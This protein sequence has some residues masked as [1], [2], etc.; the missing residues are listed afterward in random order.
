[1]S[2][3]VPMYGFGGGGGAALNFKVVG[4]TSTPASPKENMIW[5]KTEK[6][7]AWHFSATQ[8]EGMQ[9]LDVWFPTGTSSPVE[10]NALKRNA[11]QV[12]PKSCMQYNNGVLEAKEAY[13]YQNAERVQFSWTKLYLYR[14]GDQCTE[15]TGGWEKKSYGGNA[16][17]PTAT[18]ESDSIKLVSGDS[19]TSVIIGC[20]NFNPSILKNFKTMCVIGTLSRG[21]QWGFGLAYDYSIGDM[22]S[23]SDIIEYKKGKFNGL[24]SLDISSIDSG[25][26]LLNAWHS[27]A[28]ITEIWLE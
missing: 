9:E 3:P 26:P 23:S 13:L 20:K 10:F 25:Y 8:P 4:G 22:D 7:G 11:I 5:V 1:M 24:Q 15:V 18:F 12:Y 27:T 21:T 19:A 6:I 16:G 17:G 28:K 2:T 14:N